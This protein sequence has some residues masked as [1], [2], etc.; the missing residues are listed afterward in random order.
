MLGRHSWANCA[1]QNLQYTDGV[2]IC[3]V[4]VCFTHVRVI[5][6]ALTCYAVRITGQS[7]CL[8]LYYTQAD[9]CG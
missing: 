3:I 6:L 4:F 2:G 5:L 7:L 1:V 8:W 9:F